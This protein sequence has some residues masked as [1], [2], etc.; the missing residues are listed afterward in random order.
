M[1]M[2]FDL[3]RA[4]KAHFLG[5]WAGVGI[6]MIKPWTW[7]FFCFSDKPKCLMFLIHV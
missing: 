2:E 4:Q 3:A 6:M 7:F 5:G 1:E